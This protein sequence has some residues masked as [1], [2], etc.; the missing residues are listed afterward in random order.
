MKR[1]VLNYQD[2]VDLLGPPPFGDKKKI[3]DPLMMAPSEEPATAGPLPK[4]PAPPDDSEQTH[5]ELTSNTNKWTVQL[6]VLLKI[7][8]NEI[9]TKKRKIC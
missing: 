1:E 7:P 9:F 2:M 4:K 5:S 3:M 8:S 6:L